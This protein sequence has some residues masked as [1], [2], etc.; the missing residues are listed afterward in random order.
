MLQKTHDFSRCAHVCARFRWAFM[1]AHE[2]TCVCSTCAHM[3]AL[4]AHAVF[5]DTFLCSSG[6]HMCVPHVS[7]HMCVPRQHT[8]THMC[9]PGVHLCVF[10]QKHTLAFQLN[11]CMR[12]PQ[13]NVYVRAHWCTSAR[14]ACTVSV[15]YICAFHMYTHTHM[16]V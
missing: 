14:A 8:S 2:C 4:V 15:V 6:I 12:V 16:C 7:E 11:T 3:C 1:L 13:V 10:Y 9:V 5:L